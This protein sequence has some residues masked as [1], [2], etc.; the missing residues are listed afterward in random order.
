MKAWYGTPE[1]EHSYN[2]AT[3]V[4]W[5]TSNKEQEILTPCPLNGLNFTLY[6][7]RYRGLATAG[8]GRVDG[9]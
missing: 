4:P 6:P 8:F 2:N 7:R 1:N 9:R 5:K 3:R